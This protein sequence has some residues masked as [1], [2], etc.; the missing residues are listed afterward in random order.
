[1]ANNS[2]NNNLEVEG[3]KAAARSLRRQIDDLTSGKAQRSQPTS[4][5]DFI[6][7]K[8]AERKGKKENS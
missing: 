7:R 5:R 6:E 2:T 4:L 8:M 1:M 3:R